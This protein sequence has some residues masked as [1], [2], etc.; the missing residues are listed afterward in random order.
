MFSSVSRLAIVYTSFTYMDCFTGSD[1][2]CQNHRCI[3]AQLHCDGFDH[4]G[5][6]S[7]EPDTCTRGQL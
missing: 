5:D 7:D 3:P 2:L 1:Y 6:N 4:C